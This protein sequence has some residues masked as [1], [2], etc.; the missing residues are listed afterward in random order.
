MVVMVARC[1]T[2]AARGRWEKLLGLL[3]GHERTHVRARRVV[4][5][6]VEH[7]SK[8]AEVRRRWPQPLQLPTLLRHDDAIVGKIK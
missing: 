3:C 2:F 4:D 1:A 5:R 6:E 8:W 7:I